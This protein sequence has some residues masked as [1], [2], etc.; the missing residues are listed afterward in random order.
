MSY[1]QSLENAQTS[2]NK[3]DFLLFIANIEKECLERYLDI[4]KQ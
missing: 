1:Y 3:E 4:I 2:G